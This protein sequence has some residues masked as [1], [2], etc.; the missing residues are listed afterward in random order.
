MTN[1]LYK[2]RA[3]RTWF[4]NPFV[5]VAGWEALFTGLIVIVAAGHLG[6]FSNTHFDGVLDTHSGASA[7]LWF[8]LSAGLVDWVCMAVVLAVIGKIASKTS[9]RIIDLAG[10]QALARWPTILS[11]LVCLPQGFRRFTEFLMKK[12]GGAA[13]TA[14]FNQGDAVVFGLAVLVILLVTVWMVALMYKSYSVSCNVKGGKAAGTFVGGILIAEILSKAII[15]SM[16]IHCKWDM[17]GKPVVGDIPAI[18]SSQITYQNVRC[19]TFDNDEGIEKIN[20]VPR[21]LDDDDP[22]NVDGIG[23]LQSRPALCGPHKWY[24]VTGVASSAEK[25]M[26]IYVNTASGTANTCI[27][28]RG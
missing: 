25:K 11:A 19:Y 2:K 21:E 18:A 24:H 14:S 16:M 8:F 28:L 15:I 4:F 5:Y 22:N 17:S 9:F 7:P 6:S 3:L 1:R 26:M 27:S 12:L 23:L 13:E 20:I 10:T